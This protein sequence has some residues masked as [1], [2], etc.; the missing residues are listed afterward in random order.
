MKAILFTLVI[1]LS[2]G[3]QFTHQTKVQSDATIKPLDAG[4]RDVS[5]DAQRKD[6]R[7]IDP[8]DHPDFV[9]C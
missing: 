8:T 4:T 7:I 1:L 5:T 6:F 2:A 3:C 9:G